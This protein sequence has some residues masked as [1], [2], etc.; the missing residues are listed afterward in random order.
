MVSWL[1]EGHIQ[2]VVEPFVALFSSTSFAKDFTIFIFY[3]NTNELRDA[4]YFYL[5]YATEE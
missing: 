5:H 2:N 3:H 4:I 1:L